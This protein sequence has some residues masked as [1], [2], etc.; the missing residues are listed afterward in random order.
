MA[1]K[2]VVVATALWAAAAVPGFAQSDDDNP[3]GFLTGT[4]DSAPVIEAELVEDV[5]AD[6]PVVAEEAD[7]SAPVLAE[8]DTAQAQSPAAPPR[9]TLD[10][11][12]VKAQK[13]AENVQ[14]VP[15][16]ITAIGGEDI[17]Q[18]NLADLNDVGNYAP[19]VTIFATPTFNFITIRGVGTG[20]NRGFEQ[21]VA[22]IIDEV[23]YGRSSYLS[24]GLLDLE[25][26]ELLRGPQGTLFGKN[27]AAGALHLRT[28]NPTV[29]FESDT[30]V[31][32]GLNN[33]LRLR[34]AVSSAIPGTNDELM[35]RVAVNY[36]RRDGLVENT[37]TGKDEN[38]LDNLSA[39]IK[40]LWEPTADLSFLV[41]LQG[42]TVDQHGD[43]AQITS[44]RPRHLAASRVYDPNMNTSIDQVTSKNEEGFV[45]R[46]YWDVTGTAKYQFGNGYEIANVI[47]FA[48]FTEDVFFDADYSPI[49]FLT[50]DNNEDYTQISEELR[51]TSP[52]GEFE[53]VA[54]LFYFYS[55]IESYYSVKG[56]LNIVEI[57]GITGQDQIRVACALLPE[58]QR[59]GCENDA[60]NASGRGQVAAL[61]AQTRQN[62]T[63]TPLLDE[64][65]TLFDQTQNSFAIFGQGTW[66]ATERWALTVGARLTYERKS[67]VASRQVFNH[68]TGG[69]GNFAPLANP[70]GSVSFPL[71]QAG[72]V[73]FSRDLSRTELDVSPKMSLE[74][75]FTDE[76]LT[77]ATVARG[78]KGG[79]YNA[80]ATYPGEL[81][82]RRE[83]STTFET[84]L[85]SEFLGGAARANVSAFY[86]K[87]DD[88]QTTAFNG[89]GFT[90]ANADARI[91][92]V[93]FDAMLAP[94]VGFILQLA[95]SYID[96]QF[97][98]FPNGP[99]GSEEPG[100]PT[101]CDLAGYD[102]PSA[103]KYNLTFTAGMQKQLF[104]LPFNTLAGLTVNYIS[105][106]T[107]TTDN[108]PLDT[109]DAT[110]TFRGSIGAA[111]LDDWWQFVIFFENITNEQH[112][113]LSNDVPTFTGSHF[114]GVIE[115][116]DAQAQLRVRF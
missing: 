91:Y 115:E 101:V 95:G 48:T 23:F 45:D 57:L 92:G 52:P 47:N 68:A 35:A 6:G 96:A 3:L 70:L 49:P 20:Y 38:N 7:A 87:Y 84:G 85:K 17:K 10:E 112:V 109:R 106:T 102:M 97:T 108:D 40:L 2:M 86:T 21:S 33:Y 12:I 89:T 43:G 50:L 46:F 113:A 27:S 67:V 76:I 66:N 54:G 24:N 4:D 60:L 59:V 51:L 110:V 69:T 105:A 103:P 13:R 107:F 63:G 19:N 104:G 1:S 34:G 15:L 61:G 41:S 5:Q 64:S 56:Y 71:I 65:L 39:R 75:R 18:R 116:F 58:A 16:S 72:S 25:T 81:E 8:E 94:A 114:G 99:C 93:E 77:Y 36:E 100:N 26:I 53:F 42:G 73:P 111:S 32:Y 11:I 22:T 44:M 80:Q 98:H 28:A 74:Y 14:D 88:F 55:N 37:T 90:I 29:D 9:A 82:F 78:F 31:T 83:K 62:A 30:D 79:G